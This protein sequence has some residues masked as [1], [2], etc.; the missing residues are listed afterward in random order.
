MTVRISHFPIQRATQWS[1]CWTNVP[2]ESHHP[3]FR[4][5]RKNCKILIRI[6][7]VFQNRSINIP[8]DLCNETTRSLVCIYISVQAARHG[9]YI[10]IYIYSHPQTDCFVLLELFSVAT[11]AGCSKPGSKPVQL[12]VRLCFRPLVHQADH[13]G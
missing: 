12:Y 4:C 7:S 8:M 6:I 11:H 9:I 5:S 13:V 10:Y 3:D 2:V 1:F